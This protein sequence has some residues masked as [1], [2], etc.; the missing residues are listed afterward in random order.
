MELGQIK[1]DLRKLNPLIVCTLCAGYYVD[2]TT[3]KEC[4]H[5][6]CKSC[7]VKYLMSS[8]HCPT[9]G[10]L[11]D[12][13]DPLSRLKLDRTLQDVVNKLLPQIGKDETRRREAFMKARQK[14]GSNEQVTTLG[15]NALYSNVDISHYEHQKVNISFQLDGNQEED[16]D[17]DAWALPKKFVRCSIL[18]K[19][20][21]LKIL[22]KRLQGLPLHYDV[23]IY[24]N[25]IEAADD[26]PLKLVILSAWQKK[27]QP[28]E[29]TYSFKNLQKSCFIFQ[30]VPGDELSD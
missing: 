25:G 16:P 2:A 14:A 10:N 6:F 18:T 24:C 22:I 4:L 3:I 29:F 13:T 15:K 23:E 7:I 17:I 30:Y 28:V 11:V 27:E 20:L 19:M 9:C 26:S 21:Q 5:S 8:H 12:E 1:I